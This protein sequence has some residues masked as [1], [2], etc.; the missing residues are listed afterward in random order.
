MDAGTT[1]TS[2]RALM[3]YT[4][5]MG[6]HA[7]VH[8][9]KMTD[10]RWNPT[11]HAWTGMCADAS[12]VMAARLAGADLARWGARSP[13]GVLD[14]ARLLAV[15]R[16]ASADL[17]DGVTVAQRL[18]VLDDLGLRH[19]HVDDVEQALRAMRSG[20]PVILNGYA[21][22]PGTWHAR[23]GADLVVPDGHHAVAA[24][25]D[26]RLGGYV[27][28]DPNSRLGPLPTTADELRTF[29]RTPP[30]E[31]QTGATVVERLPS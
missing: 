7:R 11:G 1:G 23:Y 15:T 17:Q 6:V 28:N 12:T 18:A 22:Q 5:G 26:A 4:A 21:D 13:Q 24:S 30:V 25:W 9:T 19:H 31:F 2:L 20:R 14:H 16:G 8:V 27:V 29:A 3:A 10:A